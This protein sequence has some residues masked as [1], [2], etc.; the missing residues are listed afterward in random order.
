MRGTLVVTQRLMQTCR[1]DRREKSYQM[2]RSPNLRSTHSPPSTSVLPGTFPSTE[3]VPGAVVPPQ[4]GGSKY[5]RYPRT[6][7]A[8]CHPH[9]PSSVVSPL[10]SVPR[11]TSSL[12]TLPPRRRLVLQHASSQTAC[13]PPEM[14]LPPPHMQPR[15]PSVSILRSTPASASITLEPEPGINLANPTP[16]THES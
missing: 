6:S 10:V 2:P 9:S 3:R 11:P 8:P 5:Q 14:L 15:L 1:V 13:Q 7:F 12:G 16:T 4:A